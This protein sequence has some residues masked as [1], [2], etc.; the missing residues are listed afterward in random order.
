MAATSTRFVVAT[1]VITVLAARTPEPVTSERLA[2]S[3]NT[4]P[5]V[6]RR[7]VGMLTR[8]GLVKT[9][10]GAGGG[11]MLAKPAS[12]ISLLDVFRAV[13]DTEVFCTHRSGPSSECPVGSSILGALLP[14]LGEAKHAMEAVL[15]GTSVDV[16]RDAVIDAAGLRAQ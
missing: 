11:A 4:N 6:V 3:A 5:T 15:A 12:E 10:L 13:E 8:A 2:G 1:H 16:L 7:L 14:V 9:R